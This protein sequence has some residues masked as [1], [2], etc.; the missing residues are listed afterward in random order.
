MRTEFVEH[1]RSRERKRKLTFKCAFSVTASQPAALNCH[2][3]GMS[4]QPPPK[5]YRKLVTT[6][7]NRA[8]ELSF[9][10]QQQ[11]GE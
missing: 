1:Q 10:F 11:K 2:S 4:R 5:D 9:A 6:F 3:V 7:Q 8:A